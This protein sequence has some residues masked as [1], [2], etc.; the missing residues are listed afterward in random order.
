ML[1]IDGVDECGIYVSANGKEVEYNKDEAKSWTEDGDLVYVVIKL[2]DII[3]NSEKLTTE[4]T[5]KAYVKVGGKTYTAKATEE[6]KEA[7]KT[8]SV[9]DMVELYYN[10]VDTQDKVEHLYNYLFTEVA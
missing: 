6:N 4:F 5:V 1:S 2:G 7:V 9:A 10:N 3:N 8:L